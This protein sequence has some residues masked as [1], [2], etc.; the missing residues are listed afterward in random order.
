MAEEVRRCVSCLLPA[1]LPSVGLN[2]AGVCRHCREYAAL[3]ERF[4]RQKP[5]LA[6][7]LERVAK[8]VKGLGRPYDCLVPLSGGKDSTYALYLATKVLGLKCLAVTFDN[9]FLADHARTNIAEATRRARADHIYYQINRDVL[10]GLYKL[11]LRNL[12]AFCPVCMLGIKL[13][14]TLFARSFSIPM[15]LHGSGQRNGYLGMIPELAP[16]GGGQEVFV[17]M[18]R[19]HAVGR[20][21]APLLTPTAPWDRQ[22]VVR[23]LCKL[24]GA[25]ERFMP[26]YDIMLYDHVDVT[27]EEAVST[28]ESEMGWQRPGTEY[29]HT[30]C[31]VHDI[32]WYMH[33]MKF[34]ELSAKTVYLSGLV[35]RG[36]MTREEALRRDEEERRR[37]A[38][39]AS[40]GPFLSGI[41]MD[42]REFEPCARD[43][44]TL[45]GYAEEEKRRKHRNPLR[46]V[47]GV[48]LRHLLSRPSGASG[49]TPPR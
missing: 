21:A 4:Q 36:E 22:R 2:T 7:D 12:G 24:M 49:G 28:A 17:R 8:R 39:P 5:Q 47:Y 26:R 35:R 40:L 3:C 9:G 6:T 42:E 20:S 31:V 11:Y 30:D 45:R 34:P 43:W 41:G 27:P 32:P 46:R 38:A 15:T 33:T 44:Q 29:E 37:N 48:L 23:I 25:P 10:M 14:C 16:G 13:T 19:E 1:S 18:V